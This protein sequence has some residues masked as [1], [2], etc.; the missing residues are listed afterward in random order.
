VS[1]RMSAII[2][3]VSWTA[4][5]L[6]CS[7]PLDLPKIASVLSALVWLWLMRLWLNSGRESSE[8]P[9]EAVLTAGSTGS[10][11]PAVRPPN[12]HITPEYVTRQQD[13]GLALEFPSW[14]TTGLPEGAARRPCPGGGHMHEPQGG[15]SRSP[16]SLIVADGSHHLER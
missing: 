13:Q 7:D 16:S 14:A 1:L 8:K 12:L 2:F 9:A 15:L 6:W 10:A 3:C 4:A 11:L 5:I